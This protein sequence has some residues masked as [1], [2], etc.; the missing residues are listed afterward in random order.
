[1]IAKPQSLI[2]NKFLGCLPDECFQLL[3]PHLK[4]VS[5]SLRETL[6]AQGNAVEQIYF[7]SARRKKRP[8]S[9]R[10]IEDRTKTLYSRVPGGRSFRSQ[11][12]RLASRIGLEISGA[13]FNTKEM[14]GRSHFNET[15]PSFL[16]PCDGCLNAAGPETVKALSQRH[17][18]LPLGQISVPAL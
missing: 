15:C 7:P 6:Y 10:T 18:G 16:F 5:L 1:M 2:G 11:G 14:K 13:C 4:P 3:L 9:K 8:D 17:T 12:V